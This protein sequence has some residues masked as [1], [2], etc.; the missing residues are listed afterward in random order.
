MT[1]GLNEDIQK[2][3]GDTRKLLCENWNCKVGK[4]GGIKIQRLFY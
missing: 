4:N 2:S 3:V 1:E